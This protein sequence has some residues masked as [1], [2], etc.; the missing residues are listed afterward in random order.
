[1]DGIDIQN[2]EDKSKTL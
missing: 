1:M 2:Y